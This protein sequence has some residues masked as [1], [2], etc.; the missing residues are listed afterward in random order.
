MK[1]MMNVQKLILG[2]CCLMGLTELKAQTSRL[3][4]FEVA[5]HAGVN[6]S[7]G[8]E[9]EPEFFYNPCRYWGIGA[10][11]AYTGM[12]GTDN[13]Q[14]VSADGRFRWLLDEGRPW[15]PFSFRPK[16]RLSTPV[17]SLGSD[18]ESGFSISLYP[19]I[20]VPFPMNPSYTVNYIPNVDQFVGSPVK[21]STVKGSG[22]RP[23]YYSARVQLNYHVDRNFHV[24]LG[25]TLSDYDLYG[26]MRR[27]QIEGK[28]LN[29]QNKKLMHLF[30]LGAAYEF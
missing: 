2:V 19:G 6:N 7:Y 25:Y 9:L 17:F 20:V 3:P 5:L 4:M 30:T 29:L 1:M 21:V 22:A 11:L 26:G 14:G 18:R 23:V 28:E 16:M 8:W 27:L 10:G 13:Y 12:L 24:S 15:Y